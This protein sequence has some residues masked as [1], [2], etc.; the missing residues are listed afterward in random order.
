VIAGSAAIAVSR[1]SGRA[2]R[3]RDCVVNWPLDVFR[4]RV[5]QDL[6]GAGGNIAQFSR[7]GLHSPLAISAPRF[8]KKLVQGNTWHFGDA[9][10][11]AT[12]SI[13]FSSA[14]VACAIQRLDCQALDLGQQGLRL[15][16]DFA[17]FL[18]PSST[19]P[20]FAGDGCRPDRRCRPVDHPLTCAMM[21][22]A[23]STTAAI[24]VLDCL[25]R[26]PQSACCASDSRPATVPAFAIT[27]SDRT[28]ALALSIRSMAEVHQT[29]IEGLLIG[30]AHPAPDPA[31][32]G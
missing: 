3:G 12:P 2:G 7:Q 29:S 23:C 32:I 18:V 1:F 5:R 30:S 15:V 27:P 9:G 6:V 22:C 14:E 13:A 17:R 11:L 26:I 24:W 8:S 31:D 10:M 20:L 19:W 21:V 16:R 28:S 25:I 4:R